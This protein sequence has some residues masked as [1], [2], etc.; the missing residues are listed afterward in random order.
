MIVNASRGSIRNYEGLKSKV[1]KCNVNV[2]SVGMGLDLHQT[3][4]RQILQLKIVYRFHL[5]VFDATIS[6]HLSDKKDS[7][8]I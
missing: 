1:Y 2:V 3:L 5:T 7:K 6:N 4:Y 8:T